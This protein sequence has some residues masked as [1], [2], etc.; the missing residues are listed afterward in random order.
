MIDKLDGDTGICFIGAEQ[1]DPIHRT[2]GTTRDHPP[3]AA[4]TFTISNAI[5]LIAANICARS[6]AGLPSIT[7]AFALIPL[8]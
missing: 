6:N 5:L 7:F 1:I 8:V 4:M 2:I 3:E